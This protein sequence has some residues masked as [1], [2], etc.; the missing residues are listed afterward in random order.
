[1]EFMKCPTFPGIGIMALINLEYKSSK[2]LV[3]CSNLTLAQVQD[4]VCIV[5]ACSEY[6]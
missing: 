1:M 3:Q 6:L 4:V 2:L 5:P